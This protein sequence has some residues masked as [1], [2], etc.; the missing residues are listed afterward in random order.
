MAGAGLTPPPP[1]WLLCAGQPQFSA[2]W[3]RGW[4][5]QLAPCGPLR[6]GDLPVGGRPLGQSC[7]WESG[8]RPEVGAVRGELGSRG[9]QVSV[10][11]A[12]AR[13]G[14]AG[15]EVVGTRGGLELKWSASAARPG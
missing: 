8:L 3:Q 11:P 4:R 7:P 10:D 6:R 14:R 1:H 2:L 15:T 5:E 12:G 9:H 13:R